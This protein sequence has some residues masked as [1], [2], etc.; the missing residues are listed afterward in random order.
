MIG[1]IVVIYATYLYSSPDRRPSTPAVADS[2]EDY[3]EPNEQDDIEAQDY[4]AERAPAL[5]PRNS[6]L[7]EKDAHRS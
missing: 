3:R 1:M 6:S 7:D 4:E 2:S 5:A